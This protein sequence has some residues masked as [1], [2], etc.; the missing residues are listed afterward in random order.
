MTEYTFEQR[1]NWPPAPVIDYDDLC[2][3]IREFKNA[4]PGWW[5]TLGECSF[6]RDA[7]CGPDM[8]GPDKHLCEVGEFNDGF[9]CDDFGSLADSLRDVMRLAL[10]AKSAWAAH[11][12]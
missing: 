2:A 11:N 1:R 5:F 10:A 9:H 4:L 6:T 3:A 8:A 7:S 12:D